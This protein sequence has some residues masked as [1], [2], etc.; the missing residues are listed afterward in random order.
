M[1]ITA[2]L[3]FISGSLIG[4]VIAKYF[5]KHNSSQ[6]EELQLLEKENF[7]LKKDI[8][9]LNQ[10]LDKSIEEFKN[11]QQRE[12]EL[13]DEKIQ[14][15]SQLSVSNTNLKNISEKLESQ[16]LELEKLQEKFTKEFKLAA[17][18]ILQQNSEQFS[19]S[20]Q[21]QLEDILTPLKLK[22]KDFEDN[23]EKK[24]L[25]ETKERSSL[26]QEIKNLM[27]LNQTL[28]SEA[29][30]LTK[31]L[32]GD[33]KKQGNWGEVILERILESSGLTKGDEYETQYS[34]T[35]INNKRIQP[36]VI[37]KLPDNKH[38]IVDS[39]VSL[40]AYEKYCNCEIDLEKQLHLKEHLSSVRSHVKGLS[41]KNYQ[42][43][44]GVNS[45]DFVLLFI[46]IESSFSL[47]IQSDQNLYNYAW[48]MKVVIVSPTTLLATLRT[49]ASVWKHEKQTKNAI[50][51]AK[52]AGDMFDKFKGFLDDMQKIEKGLDMSTKAYH[53]AFK[54]LRSGNGNLVSRAEKL[55]KLG[56][57][58]NKD[59]PKSI[60]DIV[61]DEEDELQRNENID[62]NKAI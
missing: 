6:N 41:E 42:T 40:I 31:A 10:R 47:A 26:K 17:N 29:Q 7:S 15:S 9:Y 52:Q 46:P 44:I 30:N 48:G 4:F 36:D 16:K 18:A 34:D 11:Q 49:I 33:N 51:I 57:K 12:R 24:Y 54:K 55:K 50:K 53:E 59:I 1:E 45:P 22:I 56:A 2:V 3:I 62:Q 20:H 28:S 61:E 58:A 23:I 60:L 32:K 8:D 38:I 35:N 19:K 14:L 25:D 21:K 5:T 27:N 39:K 37:I 13:Q 43:A